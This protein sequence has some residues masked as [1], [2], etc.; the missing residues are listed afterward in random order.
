MPLRRRQ[1]AVRRIEL[2]ALARRH[3]GAGHRDRVLP[4]RRRL[5]TATP[6]RRGADAASRRWRHTASTEH[7]HA[8]RLQH[9]GERRVRRGFVA[10]LRLTLGRRE[11][12]EVRRLAA[13][14]HRVL[15][16]ARKHG[17]AR[18]AAY[19]RRRRAQRAA[20]AL[21]LSHRESV[22]S[23]LKQ[24]T[25]IVMS[26]FPP[27]KKIDE[28]RLNSA[29]P[30]IVAP[31]SLRSPSHAGHGH[32]WGRRTAAQRGGASIF[33]TN[34]PSRP[35]DATARVHQGWVHSRPKWVLRSFLPPP[36]APPPPPKHP[37][38]RKPGRLGN[39]LCEV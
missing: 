36:I 2:R 34:R 6:R 19:R 39:H 13:Q 23:A 28:L 7:P 27:N 10:F 17:E 5:R 11:R 20:R 25:R 9:E 16:R 30:S 18:A 21:R 32:A 15:R 38:A 22:Q 12:R 14:D 33:S 4:R 37:S 31:R 35:A 3:D 1:D 26:P 8:R 24:E 29:P